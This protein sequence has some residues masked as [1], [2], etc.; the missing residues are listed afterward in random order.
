MEKM[1]LHFST[2]KTTLIINN[3]SFWSLSRLNL[4]RF[5]FSVNIE[6]VIKAF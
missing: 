3:Q 1:L 4:F 6:S 2:I 5:S